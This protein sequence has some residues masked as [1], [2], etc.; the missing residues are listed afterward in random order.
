M[1]TRK[2]YIEGSS[3]HKHAEEKAAAVKF[4]IGRRMMSGIGPGSR[5]GVAGNV[6]GMLG[7]GKSRSSGRGPG[8]FSPGGAGAGG[9]R[10]K[11]RQSG[12]GQMFRRR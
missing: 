12:V 11:I 4:G 10:Q 5:G 2:G 3:L 1:R 9:W 7:S 8:I 6:M